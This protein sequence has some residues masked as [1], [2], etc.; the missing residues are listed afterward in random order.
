[1]A[2]STARRPAEAGSDDELDIGILGSL[3]VRRG[4]S[5]LPLGGRQ[6]RAVFALLVLERGRTV[7]VDRIADMLWGEHPPPGHVTT[8]QTYVFHLRSVLEPHRAK[9]APGEVIVSLPG[10]GYRLDVPY[11]AVDVD[12]FEEL[13]R[14]GRA[15]LDAGDPEQAAVN[16]SAALGLWRGDVLSDLSGLAPVDPLASGLTEA[17]LAV[18]EDWAASE[19]ALG[20]TRTVLP[21]LDALCSAHPLREGLWALRMLAL[22]LSGRQADALAA[23]RAVQS[24]LDD[25][26]GVRPSQELR[27]L[28]ERMLRQDPALNQP[29]GAAIPA[30]VRI[31]RDVRISRAVG[32]GAA[33]AS[34]ATV[35]NPSA[36][37]AEARK[38]PPSP[39]PR[40]GGL[41]SRLRSRRLTAA[42]V[43]ILACGLVAGGVVW[44]R[45]SQTARPVPSNSVGPVGT[46][47]LAGEAVAM[48]AV[49]VALAEAA[50]SVW[51]L[52]ETESTV[53]RVDPDTRRVL[54]TIP[55]VGDDPKAIAA[56]GNDIWVAAFAAR[57]VTRISAAAN[58]VVDRI[59]VGNKPIS[60]VASPD[61]V[62]V[63]NSADNTL[64]RIDPKTDKT[65]PPLPVGD[66]PSALALEGTSLWV[67]NRGTATVSQ[68]DTRTGERAAADV[69]V[70]AGPSALAVTP[71]DVWVAN[72][73][74]E[75]VSRIDRA[76][77]QVTKI[78][79]GDGP[80]SLAVVDAAVWVSDT[81]S[82]SLSLID[83]GANAVTTVSVS[84]S[85]KGIARI[86]DQVWVASSAFAGSEHVGGTLT[87]A[88]GQPFTT[89]DPAFAYD[90]DIGQ[91]LTPVYDG[92]VTARGGGPVSAGILV[93]DLATELPR[94][95]DGGKTYIFT[96]RK[97]VSYSDGR[98][99]L[100]SDFARGFRR[101]L[102]GD[103]PVAPVNL[104][105]AEG[106]IKNASILGLP[107]VVHRLPRSVCDLSRGVIAD[108][109]TGLLTLH[110]TAP[111]ADFVYL[112]GKVVPSP[113]GT[114]DT[115]IGR[116]PLPS[117]GPYQI[118]EFDI[119]GSLTLV[120][121]PHFSAWS[122]AAQPAGYPDV[123]RIQ[124]ERDEAAAVDAVLNG[125]A[126][127]TQS[128]TR[129][130]LTTT[131]PTRTNVSYQENAQYVYLNSK[132][133][134]FDRKEVRQAL[135]YAVDRRA[136]IAL[137][138]GS[139]AA[140]T[141]SCQLLPPSFPGYRPYCPYQ[142]GRA[143]GPYA[144][145]DMDKARLLVRQSGTTQIPITIHRLAVSLYQQFPDYIAKILRDLGYTVTIEDIPPG[146]DDPWSPV[147]AGYQIF[148][149]WGWTPDYPNPASF[150]YAQASC[151]TP[152]MNQFCDQAVETLAKAAS[153]LA[154]SDPNAAL[155]DWTEVD[156]RLT[157]D[158]AFLTLGNHKRLDV[159]SERL[160]NLQQR[161]GVGPDISQLW[162]R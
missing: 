97:G 122:V 20:H 27:T 54:E 3:V 161:G 108:D 2:I 1:M 103:S 158:A 42:A 49:P 83:A 24:I 62:W 139:S 92:L 4:G 6:Q 114:P 26:L 39:A 104:V 32:D 17:R 125:K 55:D 46:H 91:A 143:D 34:E 73:L 109:A 141:L 38:G 127:L 128:K 148:T 119:D 136:L 94:P 142:T 60:V 67:A 64:Q 100:A 157:D 89:I 101:A 30:Y 48:P 99:V 152:N 78:A 70:D 85:P 117:T 111:D 76:S 59:T 150:Y 7:S 98:P 130:D 22:Y 10:G 77:G 123:I 102:V 51:V 71:T 156:R 82:G 96:I 35:P 154:T 120:R 40:L 160:G 133:P 155:A 93:P 11:D 131:L 112:A 121:N 31:S 159:T 21:E 12:R 43:A 84:S 87:V 66:G 61:A 45:R 145:P 129:F 140:A 162:V 151:S 90:A 14:R 72:E 28:H 29:N 56:S 86:G 69:P 37:M 118:G 63:A 124:V 68:I 149:M 116:T 16:L 126:D 153:E 81:N 57:E 110:L 144:G 58:K 74:S 147:L 134:P 75:T 132:Q 23:Y 44:A 47:G 41:S 138:P 105:G 25:E 9:G 19:L 106:C 52:N 113:P 137:Y 33:G 107:L 15:A 36:P 95:V 13:A 146:G 115:D 65:D 135:N 79:V 88:F 53:T 18:R 80:S 5:V 50:G 8:I